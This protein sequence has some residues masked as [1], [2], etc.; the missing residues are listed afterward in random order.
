MKNARLT[1]CLV[2]VVLIIGSSKILATVTYDFGGE[3]DIDFP[4]NDRVYVRNN[5]SNEPTILNFLIG[6]SAN[7]MHVW[8]TSQINISGGTIGNYFYADGDSRVT[9]SSGSITGHFEAGY[10]SKIDITGGSISG[11]QSEGYSQSVISN[12]SIGSMLINSNSTV[13]LENVSIGQS[14]QVQHD[15]KLTIYSGSIVEDLITFNNS[16][17][18]I[19]GGTIG[20]VFNINDQSCI[21]IHGSNFNYGYG[22]IIHSTGVLTGTLANGEPINN[23]FYVYDDAKIILAPVPEPASLLLLGLGGLL[24]KKR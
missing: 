16:Q 20:D 5:V 21:I 12:A 2:A 15:S 9:L 19:L 4:I 11:F 3:Y 17:I 6:G 7:E 10:N 22:E 14:V 13:A 24:I 1:I 8:D 23:R 18:T